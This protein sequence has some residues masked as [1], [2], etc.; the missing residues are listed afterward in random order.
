MDTWKRICFFRTLAMTPDTRLEDVCQQHYFLLNLR[1]RSADTRY[2]YEVAYR[3]FSR[4]LGRPASIADLD[5]D[6]ITIWMG[7]LLRGVNGRE[8]L[9]ESTVRERAG[10][11][12]ALWTW[13][14]KRGVVAKWP[15]FTRP[16]SADPQ[17]LALTSDQLQA[18]F[19]SARKERGHI[20][21]IPAD[22][23]CLSFFAFVW[24]TA[25]RKSAALA[26]QIPWL[27]LAGARASIPAEARKGKRKWACY[28][29][30]PETI[31]LLQAVIDVDPT[32]QLVWPWDKC[33]GSY[34]TLY[35]R[36]LRDAG[37]PVD[38]KHKTHSLR[39]SHATYREAAGGDATRQ[40]RHSDRQTTVRHYLDQSKMPPDTTKLFIPWAG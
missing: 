19:R 13:L 10:R 17:P 29:L 7:S 28:D 2:Q 23:W 11:I 31:P 4:H 14:A 35:N 12:G 25:E 16:E 30:W 26:V 18:L 9:A 21:G 15:T 27:D 40:L 5:D 32:R 37:I 22:L 20:A 8:P 3:D 39:V 24:N 36:I 38:R 1:I 33:E 6:Q 34:Y